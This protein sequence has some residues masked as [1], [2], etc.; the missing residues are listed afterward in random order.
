MP[1]VAVIGYDGK[2]VI[3]NVTDFAD[4]SYFMK[5][6]V[7]AIRQKMQ[8]LLVKWMAVGMRKLQPFRSWNREYGIVFTV[9]HIFLTTRPWV[10]RPDNL[11]SHSQRQRFVEYLM[12]EST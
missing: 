8:W 7:P 1:S 6:R 12:E 9:S 2:T 11:N 4:V 10:G 5:P 3:K